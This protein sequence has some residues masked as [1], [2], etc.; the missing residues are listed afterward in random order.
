MTAAQDPAG[1]LEQQP[2]TGPA[3]QPTSPPAPLVLTQ[4]SAMVWQAIA[5]RRVAYDT[6]MWQTPAL[7]LTAQAFLLTLALGGQTSPLARAGAALVSLVL[8]MMCLQLMAKHRFHERIDASVLEGIERRLGFDAAVGV[9]PHT[10]K[11]MLSDLT[12]SPLQRVAG[13]GFSSFRLWMAGQAVFLLI[14]VATFVIVV[15]GGSSLLSVP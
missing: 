11:R 12:P 1:D 13:I 6:M 9:Q 15:V 4:E 5:A 10:P 14:A 8:A 7:G 2:E 3:P